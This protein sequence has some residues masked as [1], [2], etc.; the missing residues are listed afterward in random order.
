MSD[1]P[2]TGLVWRLSTRWRA[3]IDR[4]VAP[5]GLTHAQ[6][7]VLAPLLSLHRAG[8]RPTQKGLADATGLEPL[9]VSKLARSLEAAGMVERSPDPADSRAVR[10]ALTPAGSEAATRATE[11]V[12]A[13]QDEL[14]A[15]LGG[16]SA[17]AARE[18][19][20][21]LITLLAGPAEPGAPSS[22]APSRDPKE[23]RS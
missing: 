1:V 18:F 11:R 5:L 20:A 3:V 19:L 6:Y 22:T 21:T 16:A 8:A 7:A 10:L 4:T 15:P 17:P 12:R 9:Y 2:V 14:L 13:L 23:S